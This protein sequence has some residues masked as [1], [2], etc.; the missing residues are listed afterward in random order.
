MDPVIY[1]VL[2]VL[3][4]ILVGGGA[5]TLCVC[6]CCGKCDAPQ[7]TTRHYSGG[8]GGGFDGEWRW[9]LETMHLKIIKV[10]NK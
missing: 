8:G 9:M 2:F 4:G 5:I 7:G 1:L 10:C 6:I 3:F